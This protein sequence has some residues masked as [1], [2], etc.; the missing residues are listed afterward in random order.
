MASRRRLHTLLCS[1]SLSFL[2]LNGASSVTGSTGHGSGRADAG[3]GFSVRLI[4]RDYSPLSPFYDPL[5]S[6]SDRLAA[7]AQRSTSRAGSVRS[8]TFPNNADHLMQFSIGTPPVQ[9]L[10]VMDTGSN[11]VWAHCRPCADCHDPR[12]P[13]FDPS[14]SS[15]FHTLPC[16]SA[17]CRSVWKLKTSCTG[18]GAVD[19]SG[20]CRYVYGYGDGSTFTAGDLATETFT[21]DSA[22]GGSMSLLEVVF[23]CSHNNGSIVDPQLV[24]L[25]GL[26][27]GP[28][29]LV[30]QLGPLAQGRFSYCLVPFQERASSSSMSFGSRAVVSEPGAVS[31]PLVL[32]E[33]RTLYHVTLGRITVGGEAVSVP[34][35]GAPDAG[36][37]SLDVIVD[38]GTTLTMLPP[39]VFRGLSAALTRKI[40]LPPTTDPGKT[41]LCYETKS[42]DGFPD[43]TFH[44]AGGADMVLHPTNAFGEPS[45]E[46][47]VCLTMLPTADW[48]VA[49]LGNQAQQNFHIAYDLV[50]KEITFAPAKCSTYSY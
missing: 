19:E 9:V 47:L 26:G 48:G 43:I 40:G 34:A 10:A 38:C 4:H 18:A 27:V 15:S 14:A 44:F 6:P 45:P 5:S 41:F 25:V 42:R 21:F 32:R 12:A 46:G 31:T 39:D 17:Q 29:S 50:K 1:F 16:G 37:S 22:D 2:L 36:G 23:G 7:A 11:L 3:A 28:A 35:R 30:S 49:L 24:G 8:R 33:D 13:V 20:T